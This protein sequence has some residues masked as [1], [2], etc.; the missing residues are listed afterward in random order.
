MIYHYK[1]DCYNVSQQP[2]VDEVSNIIFSR[3]SIS[4]LVVLVISKNNFMIVRFFDPGFSRYCKIVK[5]LNDSLRNV[6]KSHDHHHHFAPGMCFLPFL[7]PSRGSPH[8][9]VSWFLQPS[10][11]LSRS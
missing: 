5:N 1:Y 2:A 3:S 8:A 11:H 6:T 9:G 10:R 4:V 7:E